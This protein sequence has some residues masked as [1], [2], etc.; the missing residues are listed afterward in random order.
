M[1]KI[2]LAIFFL[3]VLVVLTL[4]LAVYLPKDF[5]FGEKKILDFKKGE[6]SKEISA[7]MEKEGIIW[8]GPAFRAYVQLKGIAG[9]LKAGEYEIQPSMNIPQIAD[10]FSRGD[11]IKKEIKIIEGWNLRDIG[12]YLENKGMFQAE[13]FWEKAGFPAVDYRKAS[14][15]PAPDD[16]SETY[17]FLKIK[18]DYVGLEGYIFP[19]TYEVGREEEA[20][21]IIIKA[22]DNFE[23]KIGED[24]KKEI[25]SRGKSVFE[26][27]TMASLLEK[28]VRGQKD[29]R[30]V[31]GILWKRFEEGMP[32]QSCASISYITGKSEAAASAEDKKIDSPFNTYKYAGLP[33]GP[34]CNPGL[35][36][37]EA[38]VYP[39]KS[40]YWY[41]LNRQD[42][43]ETIFSETLEEHNAAKA[44]YLKNI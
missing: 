42:T 36:S 14:D 12:F 8:W 1:K 34:I 21:D 17:D 2:L 29:K 9:S 40:S 26:I 7:K 31:S 30:I 35:E 23:N 37:I 6:G 20:E 41:F 22:L 15:L 5:G 13:E 27:M 3:A 19:D 28:E 10:K 16:F 43:G 39:E 32:L 24:I 18:P 44:K 4:G 25:K 11:V 38:A 33:L